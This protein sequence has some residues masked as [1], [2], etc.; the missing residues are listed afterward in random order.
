[1]ALFHSRRSIYI[2]SLLNFYDALVVA[3]TMFVY[4]LDKINY[5]LKLNQLLKNP[6]F[7]QKVVIVNRS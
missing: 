3:P 2:L 1:M 7:K 4:V 5:F 6:I